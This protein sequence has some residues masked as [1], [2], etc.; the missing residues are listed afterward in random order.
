MPL[1]LTQ[2]QFYDRLLLNMLDILKNPNDQL[3]LKSKRVSKEELQDADFQL[4]LENLV[5]IMEEADGIGIAA[6]QVNIQKRVIVVNTGKGTEVFINPKI[7][8][9]SIRKMKSEEGCLSVPGVLGVVTRNKSIKLK[10]LDRDGNKIQRKYSNL[11]AIIFQHEIDHLDGILFI[12]KAEKI[13]RTEK[14]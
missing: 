10:A 4:F 11:D 3:R 14:L 9:S 12:D 2:S 5:E 13:T 1:S 7:I 8:S 6:P